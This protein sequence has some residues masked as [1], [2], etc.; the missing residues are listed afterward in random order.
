M[1]GEKENHK[2][3]KLTEDSINLFKKR[4]DTQTNNVTKAFSVEVIWNRKG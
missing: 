2:R 3:G 4:S 1:K